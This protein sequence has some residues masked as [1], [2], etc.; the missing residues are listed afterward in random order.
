MALLQTLRKPEL[1]LRRER[2]L[3]LHVTTAAAPRRE[4]RVFC[5]ASCLLYVALDFLHARLRCARGR[6]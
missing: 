2:E 4:W 6:V 1:R 3:L 5:A